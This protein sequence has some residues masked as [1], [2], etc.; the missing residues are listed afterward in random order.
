MI[1]VLV[2]GWRP[3]ACELVPLESLRVSNVSLNSQGDSCHVRGG[4]ASVGETIGASEVE[5]ET[6]AKTASRDF[7]FS[8]RCVDGAAESILWCDRLG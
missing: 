7:W 5:V 8:F 1:F 4:G 2:W 6:R 3:K